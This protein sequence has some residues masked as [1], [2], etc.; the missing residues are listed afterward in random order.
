MFTSINDR[1]A[2]ISWSL[3]N[4]SLGR[5]L[6][7]KVVY[8]LGLVGLGVAT[9]IVAIAVKRTLQCYLGK[10]ARFMCLKTH[11]HGFKSQNTRL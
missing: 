1:L 7:E 9:V 11:Y 3:L 2:E 4:G 10:S 6:P 8:C 5:I